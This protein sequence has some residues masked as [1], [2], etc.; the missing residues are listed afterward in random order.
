MG[1]DKAPQAVIAGAVAAARALPE[2]TVL[3]IGDESVMR[4]ELALH[5]NG[6]ENLQLH[7]ASQVIE[8]CEAPG[9]AIRQKRDSSI[10]VGM[11]LVR[12]G[13][14]DAMVSAGNSGA[15]MAGATLILKSQPG[16]DR[17]AIATPMPTMAGGRVIMLDSGAT[18]DCKPQNLVQFA[19]LG[20]SYATQALHC[21]SPRVGLLSIG[22]EPS[23]GDE[24]T[25]E[26]H[27]LFLGMP[28]INFIGNVEPKEML[29][30]EVDVVVCDGFVGNL[31]LKAGEGFGELVMKTLGRELNR[32]FCRRLAAALLRPAFRQVKR[33]F[34][35]AEYGGALLLG[36]NGVVVIGHG[37][38]NAIAIENAIRV[39]AN[40]A[41]YRK[42][43]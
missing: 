16:I 2:I 5:G 40:A 34:D 14:A 8:M 12:K 24:L 10:V 32:G 25:K 30:G 13:E 43:A 18:T 11:Y 35:Y 29:Q 4:A 37:R 19:E 33:L 9:V 3:L 17:P 23:K 41:R 15:M 22:E 27:Q 1:G 31:M 36:V 7:H 20:S 28:N 39:A 21:P 38:S 6:S 42:M 26:T